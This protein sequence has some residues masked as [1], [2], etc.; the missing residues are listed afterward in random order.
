MRKRLVDFLSNQGLSATQVEQTLR[1]SLIVISVI[2]FLILMT[3][4]VAFDDVFATNDISQLEV[5]DITSRDIRASS[6]VSYTSNILTDQDQQAA[7]DAVQP[8][9]YPTDTDVARNQFERLQEILAFVDDVRADPYATEQQ[10]V[11]DI[12]QI[13]SLELETEDIQAILEMDDATWGTVKNEISAVLETQMQDQIREDSLNNKIELIP[14]QVGVS[15]RGSQLDVIVAVVEDLLR[16]NT[17]E[18]IEETEA[19]RELAAAGVPDRIRNF[20]QGETIVAAGTRISDL[21]YEALSETGLLL[22]DTLRGQNVLRA[23]LVSLLVCVL[24]VIYLWQV[25]RRLFIDD[26]RLLAILSFIFLAM[27]LLTRFL[28]VQGDIY[29]FPTATLALVLVALSNH[30][31]ATMASFALALLAGVM[32]GNSLEVASLI[33][34]GGIVAALTLRRPERLNAFF[35]SGAYVSIA[36]VIVV[37]IF[38][39]AA[40]VED[41]QNALLTPVAVQLLSSTMLAPA[42]AIAVMYVLTVAFNLP[43]PLKLL[44]LSQ[45]NKPLLQRLLR[46]APGTYQHSLQVANLAEQAANSI[47]ADAQ[48]VHVAALYHDIGKM[49]NPIYFTENQ[50]DTGNPHDTLNDPYRSADIIID[51]VQEGVELAK[52]YRL[53]KRMRDFIQEHHGTTRVYVFYQ[54]AIKQMGGDADAVDASDFS[55]PGPKPRSRETSLLMLADSCEAAIRSMKPSTKREIQDVIDKIFD[56]KRQQGQLDES[57][58]TLSDLNEIRKIFVEVLQGVFH[59]RINYREAVSRTQRMRA[60]SNVEQIETAVTISP[61]DAADTT[62]KT[63]PQTAT[64]DEEKQPSSASRSTAELI[65]ALAKAEDDSP[66]EEVPPLPRRNGKNTPN[67]NGTAPKPTEAETTSD[68]DAVSD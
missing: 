22:S 41:V 13:T 43:T 7:R 47:G 54:Q 55:Y 4:I 62:P 56:D 36:S 32:A 8:I 64:A 11:D 1:A 58:L 39:L 48:L 59:P 61:V 28:G 18:N 37:I 53:P 2:L 40:P 9:Y 67:G 26:T 42:A 31:I 45:P 5:N 34:V 52:Q 21:D 29:L 16:P 12:N 63:T 25:E 3:M 35:V 66:L 23:F 68:P 17:F 46:E 6:S 50:Q 38:R 44:D 33:T 60:V 19:E 15:F 49:V 24:A 51:H 10:Q 14:N 20:Q 65:S 57:D 30:Q 27:L